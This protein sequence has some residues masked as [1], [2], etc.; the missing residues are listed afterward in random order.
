[1]STTTLIVPCNT[2]NT[3]VEVTR[4]DGSVIYSPTEFS[5]MEPIYAGIGISSYEE[6]TPW[7][8]PPAPPKNECI[9]GCDSHYDTPPTWA[10]PVP[11]PSYFA[12][13]AMLVFLGMA[14][15]GRWRRV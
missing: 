7:V 6:Y 3:C 11:E 2:G 8:V 1:M 4:A 10:T 14:L 9:V 12:V 13:M 15:K 5:W